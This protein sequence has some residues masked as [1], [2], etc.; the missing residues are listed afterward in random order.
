MT[1]GSVAVV[2][3]GSL[4]GLIGSPETLAS[5]VVVLGMTI[6]IAAYVFGLGA[7]VHSRFGLRPTGA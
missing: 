1:R 4:L 5:L 7:L 6:K 2:L 3:V